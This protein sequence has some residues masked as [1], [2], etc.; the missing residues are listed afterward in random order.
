MFQRSVVVGLGFGR[1]DVADRLEQAPIVEPVDPFEGGILYGLEAAP[2]AASVDDFR[3]VETV[4][5]FGQAL[6]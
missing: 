1:R 3:F 2:R 4:D 6:S 5:G